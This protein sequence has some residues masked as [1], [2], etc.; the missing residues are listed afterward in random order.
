MAVFVL[1]HG[2]WVG[3]WYWCRVAPLLQAGGHRV[4]APTLTGL[5]E[6]AHLCS[7]AVNLDTHVQDV[8]NVLQFEELHEVVLVGHSYGGMVITGVA[9]RAAERIAHLCYL[10]AFVPQD[11]QALADFVGPAMVAGIRESARVSSD[12][13]RVPMPFPLAAV[14][15]EKEAD[16]SWM[17]PRL[18]A[19]PLNTILQPVRLADPAARALPRTFIYCSEPPIGFF[20]GFA[21]K[22]RSEG[23]RYREIASGHTAMVT[24][25]QQVADLLLEVAR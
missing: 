10:D 16:I 17:M 11:G 23:W 6:R 9:E 18:T 25:P 19:H 4:F 5:G 8:T 24:A 20:E 14:G 3:G 15:I 22:A 21:E 13:S 2:G 7:L 1:V 12:G